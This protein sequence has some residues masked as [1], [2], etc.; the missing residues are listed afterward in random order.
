MTI[1]GKGSLATFKPQADDITNTVFF[2]LSSTMAP[3]KDS[4]KTVKTSKFVLV[5]WSKKVRGKVAFSVQPDA[6]VKDSNQ[7]HNPR[8]EAEIEDRISLSTKIFSLHLGRVLCHGKILF[9]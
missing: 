9:L 2:V 3:K 4:V 6:T 5:M 8:I 7:F 1:F